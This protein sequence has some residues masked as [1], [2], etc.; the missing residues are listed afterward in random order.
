MAVLVHNRWR[1]RLSTS[2]L[3]KALEGALELLGQPEAEVALVLTTD[4]EITL[5]NREYLG[6]NRATNVL[7]FPQGGEILGDIIISVDT[8]RREAEAGRMDL[9]D[10]LIHLA[11]HGLLHLVGYDHQAGDSEA[12]RMVAMEARILKALVGRDLGALENIYEDLFSERRPAVAKLAVNVDH[13]ATVREAR[14]VDYPDPVQAATLAILGGAHGIVVHLRGDRR[15]IQDRDVRLLRQIVSSRLILEMA[16]TE[17]MISFAEEVRPDQVTLVPERR[18]E[19]TTEGGLNLKGRAKKIATV[20]QR[21][22]EAH[23]EVSI[24]I[25][26]DPAQIRRAAKVGADIVEIHTGHYAEAKELAAVEQE[27]LRIKEAAEVAREAGLRVH[28]GHGLH[29]DNISQVAAIPEIEEFSIG[30]AIVSRA[31]FVGLKEAVAEMRS[32]IEKAAML[33]QR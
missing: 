5:F 1:R 18:Q 32:L 26:P 7:S 20:V 27:L 12:Q 30:H 2:R 31:I 28:A 15:H 11:I 24:F 14:K 23:I 21:L 13:V 6:R 29:Y 16:A 22:K 3:K 33:R 10:R 25:D 8:A 4:E 9:Y 19:V 17:E